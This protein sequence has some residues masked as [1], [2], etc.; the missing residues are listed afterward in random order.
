MFNAMRFG[1]YVITHKEEDPR[2]DGEVFDYS[3]MKLSRSY[4]N[5][6]R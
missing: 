5:W 1:G 4:F 3:F 6:G 2:G